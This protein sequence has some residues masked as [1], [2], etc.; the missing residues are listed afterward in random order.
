[1]LVHRECTFVQPFM[2]NRAYFLNG[3]T[4]T[5]NAG[6]G[7]GDRERKTTTVGGSAGDSLALHNFVASREVRASHPPRSAE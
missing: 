1:M 4:D 6:V 7:L 2:R 3:K 5:Q